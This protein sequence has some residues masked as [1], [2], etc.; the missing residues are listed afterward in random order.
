MRSPQPDDT[1]IIGDPPAAPRAVAVVLDLRA[2][3]TRVGVKEALHD[4]AQAAWDSAREHQGV[5]HVIIA[6]RLEASVTRHFD[7][8]ASAIATRFHSRLERSTGRDIE[9]TLIDISECA[10]PELLQSRLQERAH[11]PA[12]AHGVVL[13]GWK[14]IAHTPIVH[15]ARAQYF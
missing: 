4:S 11:D 15:A 1:G 2:V 5:R 10:D 14:D 9:F 6:A 3:T 12:G 8:I 7:R 13:L